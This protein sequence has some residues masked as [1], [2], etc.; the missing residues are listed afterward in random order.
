L[1]S[2]RMCSS[3][4][5]LNTLRKSRVGRRS[6][7]S[8]SA[9]RE[10][11]GQSAIARPPRTAPPARKAQLAVR[12][13]C[14]GAV[15]GG[16]AAEL[17]YHEHRCLRPQ[18]SQLVRQCLQCFVE[19]CQRVAQ[20][21]PRRRPDWHAY[22]HP[23]RA[24]PALQRLAP[25]VRPLRTEVHRQQN[26]EPAFVAMNRAVAGCIARSASAASPCR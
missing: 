10:S 25:H 4:T 23:N 1:A 18:R 15:Y 2:T 12:D 13:R 3:S 7:L 6:R 24:E 17:G 21:L 16:G 8:S 26:G 14:P 22:H 9:V 19:T 11:P 5:A 20:A